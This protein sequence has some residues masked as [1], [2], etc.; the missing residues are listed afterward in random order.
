V[1][2]K[3]LYDKT[4]EPQNT[5]NIFSS[6]LYYSF[7]S[8]MAHVLFTIVV[9]VWVQWGPTCVVLCFCFVFLT[10]LIRYGPAWSYGS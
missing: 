6:S 2:I 5:G 3:T 7:D 10:D 9:F 8:R 4:R 1:S